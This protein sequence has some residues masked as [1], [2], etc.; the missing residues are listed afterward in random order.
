MDMSMMNKKSA[1]NNKREVLKI[2]KFWQIKGIGK[3]DYNV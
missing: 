3:V 1:K 2:N